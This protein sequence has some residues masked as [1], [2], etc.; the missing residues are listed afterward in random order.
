MPFPSGS[1]PGGQHARGAARRGGGRQYAGV[2]SPRP[3]RRPSRAAATATGYQTPGVDAHTPD[4]AHAHPITTARN[5][6]A[7][8]GGRTRLNRRIGAGL[9]DEPAPE[10]RT[11]QRCKRCPW[12][13][14]FS[15]AWLDACLVPPTADVVIANSSVV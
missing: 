13:D 10:P 11:H 5:R 14:A 8:E 4:K 12:N 7:L 1:T 3:R 6:D 9:P 15:A 2:G